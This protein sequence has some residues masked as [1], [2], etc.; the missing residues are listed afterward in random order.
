VKRVLYVVD[1]MQG[2]S[3]AIQ[4]VEANP[5]IGKSEQYIEMLEDK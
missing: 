4:W 3:K 2:E 5:E 1:S